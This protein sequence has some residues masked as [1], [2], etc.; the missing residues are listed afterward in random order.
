M[1]L[2]YKELTQKIINVFYE[3]YNTLGYGFLEKVY[4]NAMLYE[5]ELRGL[6]TD[7]QIPINVNY[8]SKLV[9]EYFSD[10]IVENKVILELKA[11][12]K[13]DSEHE[14]QLL[15]YLKASDIE[16]GLLLN[17][18]KEPDFKRK[19]FTNDEKNKRITKV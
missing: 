4:E 14:N 18:G 17:F 11:C 12:N 6:K 3:V 13:L 10:I 2:L 16:V 5:L 1:E 15:N 8:K 7:K 9:G 19:I